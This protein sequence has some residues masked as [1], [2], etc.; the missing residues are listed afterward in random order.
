VTYDSGAAGVQSVYVLRHCPV[1]F[2]HFVNK[3]LA[4]HMY[5]LSKQILAVFLCLLFL[6]VAGASSVSIGDRAPDF[7]LRSLA[8][9]NL[10]LSEYRSEVVVLNFWATW[11]NKCRDA[12]PVLNSI[13]QQYQPEGLQVFSVGVDGGSLKA[14]ELATDMGITFPIMPDNEKKTVSRMYELGSMPLTLVIDRE[15]NVRHIQKG[16]K[17]DSGEKIEAVV[18]KLLAG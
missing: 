17:R 6:T 2:V 5:K 9:K 11:C 18:A 13:Y 16:F 10:R 7:A 3:G 15:G 8:G 14:A 1:Y 4:Q 12:M